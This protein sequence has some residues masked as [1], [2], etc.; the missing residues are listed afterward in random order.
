MI[1]LQNLGLRAEARV[2]EE[3]NMWLGSAEAATGVRDDF[4]QTIVDEA[5]DRYS[6]ATSVP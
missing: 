1:S 5:I 2:H 4:E 3:V 6:A